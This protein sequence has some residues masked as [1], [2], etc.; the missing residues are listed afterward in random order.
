MYKVNKF[1]KTSQAESYF[2]PTSLMKISGPDS[3]NRPHLSHPRL[4]RSRSSPVKNKLRTKL[5]WSVSFICSLKL[6]SSQEVK[7]SQDWPLAGQ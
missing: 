6:K 7:H 3:K 1:T 4:S 5:S 2:G